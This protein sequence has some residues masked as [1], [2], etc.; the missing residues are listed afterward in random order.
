MT[1]IG[2]FAVGVISKLMPSFTQ[3]AVLVASDPNVRADR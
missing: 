2:L 3:L 1:F